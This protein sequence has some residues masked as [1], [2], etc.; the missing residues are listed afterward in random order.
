MPSAARIC[1]F[2]LVEYVGI[3][4]L[5]VTVLMSTSTG[6]TLGSWQATSSSHTTHVK[7]GVGERRR[8]LLGEVVPDA[9]LDRPVRI[10]PRELLRI[11]T[12]LRMGRAVGVTLERDRGHGDDRSFGKLALEF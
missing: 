8:G 11:G 12:W 3:V 7:D 5:S 9:A 6:C 2:S 4:V 10:A 1:L